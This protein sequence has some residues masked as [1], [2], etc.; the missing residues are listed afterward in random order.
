[1]LQASR[2]PADQ[3]SF[4]LLLRVFHLQGTRSSKKKKQAKLK[5][6]MATVKK[7]NKKGEGSGAESFAAIHLL[8][9]PQ[10]FAEKLF[11]RLQVRPGSGTFV[12]TGV[13]GY[14]AV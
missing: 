6:V 9:D 2:A 5:R 7:A 13:L 4:A 12:D 10:T 8:H 3:A 1:M 14:A 11:A